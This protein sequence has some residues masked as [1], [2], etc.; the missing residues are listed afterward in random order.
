MGTGIVAVLFYFIPFKARWLY[1]LS[2]ILFILDAILFCIISF[3]TILRYALEPTLWRATLTDPA[4][5]PFL[6]T[7]PIAFVI[8]IELWV[9]ICVPLWGEWASTLAWV[10][11]IVD[12]IFAVIITTSLS[13]QL[14]VV[15]C[16]VS[17][18]FTNHRIRMSKSH[19]DSL[20]MVTAVQLLPIASTV[21]ASG[22]GAEVAGVLPS[23]GRAQ[24]TLVASF[25]LWGMAMPLSGIILIIYYQRLAVHK[26]PSREVI[27]S[28]FLPLSP[29]GFG[30]Y[31]YV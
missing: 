7:I 30:S 19:L 4:I 21:I 10:C 20:K 25:V 22:V 27:V 17:M 14:Y 12:A 6:G 5:A 11:W 1:Y 3:I 9:F 13:F 8:L 24:A 29:L 18:I 26:L 28:C 15:R 16:L 23:H 2:I 31:R